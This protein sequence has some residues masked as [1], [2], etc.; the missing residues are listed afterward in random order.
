MSVC[1]VDAGCTG[2]FNPA[3]VEGFVILD[4][5]I[6]HRTILSPVNRQLGE[7]LQLQLGPIT[8]NGFD[9]IS[10]FPPA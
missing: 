4:D 9:T 7:V 1:V 3:D 6:C 10:R 5:V 8:L 2:D